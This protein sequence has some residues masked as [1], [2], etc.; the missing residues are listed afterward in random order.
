MTSCRF[1]RAV[2]RWFGVLL[3]ILKP[4]LR[5]NGGPILMIQVENEYGSFTEGCD[6]KYTTFLRDLTIKHL[7][8]DVV[9]YTSEMFEMG[10][11]SLR[12]IMSSHL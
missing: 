8:D 5:K 7:G 11:T 2:E 4:S 9:L 6:R 12:N 3:P 1:I 10:Y